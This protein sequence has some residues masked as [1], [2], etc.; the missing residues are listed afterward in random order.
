MIGYPSM[1][2]VLLLAAL[3]GTTLIVVRSTIFRPIRRL[4]P[5]LLECSQCTGA[6]VGAVAGATGL[7]TTGHGGRVLDALIVG[8]ATSFLALLADAVLLKLL[9]D[10]TEPP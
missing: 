7:V 3:I 5:D 1:T 6:W 8:A 10:P 9:G 2:A 4:W